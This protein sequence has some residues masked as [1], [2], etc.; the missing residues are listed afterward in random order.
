M[1]LARFLQVASVFRPA[2]NKHMSY[3]H[4][5]TE[6]VE[7]VITVI[8]LNRPQA[9]NA[10]SQAMAEELAHAIHALETQAD[11]R[12]LLLTGAGE[13]SFCAGADLKE[14]QGM[15]NMQWHQQHAAF[16]KALAAI[17]HCKKPIIA[18]VN[19][20]AMGG[21]M[22]LAMACD[23]IYA[24]ENARFALTEATLG[25]MPGM[26][27]TQT[28]PRAIGVARAKEY[29]YLGKA[30][31][32]EEAHAIGL[33]NHISAQGQ[34]LAAA[35]STAQAIAANAPLAVAAIKRSVD[36]GIEQP[37]ASALHTE[38]R[39]YNGLLGTRDRQEGINAWNEKRKPNFNGS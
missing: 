16:E 13:K 15:N 3:N 23:F 26:G 7:G 9:A 28:L 29:L 21:G 33:V 22:E 36:Q 17:M 37:L 10:L 8:T 6:T 1:V 12:V 38:L 19:G 30:M 11:I 25:I 24:A 32:A 34:V 35:L 39:N 14:R 4:I 5:L 31:N 20:A 27:G 18:T 2:Y